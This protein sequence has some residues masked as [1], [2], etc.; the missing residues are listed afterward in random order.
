MTHVQYIDCD[1]WKHVLGIVLWIGISVA[2]GFFLYW[3]IGLYGTQ[4]Y[5]MSKCHDE[6]IGHILEMTSVCVPDYAGEIFFI[7][8][9][10]VL[11]FMNYFVIW[12]VLNNHY[13]WLEIRC[14]KKPDKV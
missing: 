2:L 12:K 14:G 1:K 4:E 5:G 7:T 11:N 13:R 8:L 3:A 9:S 10:S 6:F